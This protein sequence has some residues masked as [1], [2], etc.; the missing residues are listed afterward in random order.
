M[1]HSSKLRLAAEF[2]ELHR[3]Q[4]ISTTITG[5]VSIHYRLSDFQAAFGMQ[6]WE[7]TRETQ[8][9]W[10]RIQTKAGEIEVFALQEVADV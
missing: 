8:G 3:V 7:C 2:I 4:P 5:I 6:G 1:R 10:T 9:R